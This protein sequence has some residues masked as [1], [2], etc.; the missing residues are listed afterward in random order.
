[1]RRGLRRATARLSSWGQAEAKGTRRAVGGLGRGA[2][3]EGGLGGAESDGSDYNAV[4][5][6]EDRPGKGSAPPGAEAGAAHCQ[7][8]GQGA[9]EE[10]KGPARENPKL[11]PP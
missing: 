10:S 2:P 6:D 1:V 4:D 5:E 3:G 7:P 11:P 9:A 8:Q